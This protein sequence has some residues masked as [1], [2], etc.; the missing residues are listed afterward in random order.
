MKNTELE[1]KHRQ[2]VWQQHTAFKIKEV[3]ETVNVLEI[4]L[5]YE[6]AY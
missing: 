5:E 4:Q 3:N 6:G 2:T 1:S